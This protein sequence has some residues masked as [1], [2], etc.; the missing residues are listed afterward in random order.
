MLLDILENDYMAKRIILTTM[1][2]L[3][4]T[5]KNFYI[6]NGKYCD[7]ISQLEA[8][9]KYYLSKIE[10]INE[11]VVIGSNAT[12][13]TNELQKAKT[14]HVL[15]KN[16]KGRNIIEEYSTEE[17]RK[18]KPSAYSVY[19]YDIKNFIMDID[20]EN[21]PLDYGE[22]KVELIEQEHINK[23]IAEARNYILDA[24]KKYLNFYSELIEKYDKEYCEDKENS[25]EQF[26]KFFKTEEK[27]K[28]ICNEVFSKLV[29][30][31][32]EKASSPK[33]NE[34]KNPVEKERV[35]EIINQENAEYYKLFYKLVDHNNENIKK[36]E[37]YIL[38]A[39]KKYLNFYSE[40]IEKYDKEYCED[41][42]NSKEQFLKFFKTE[43]KDKDI[44]NE[45]FSK[46]VEKE[47]EKASSPKENEQ[48]NPVKK[49]R[50]EEILNQENAEYYEL[51]ADLVKCNLEIDIKYDYLSE[52]DKKKYRHN[53]EETCDDED[54]LSRAN[55]VTQNKSLSLLG[56]TINLRSLLDRFQ[57]KSIV[58]SID[59]KKHDEE[60]K[61]Y[62]DD[63]MKLIKQLDDIDNKRLDNEQQYAKEQIYKS[64][65][66]DQK[67]SCKEENKNVKIRFVS[68]KAK[69]KKNKEFDNFNGI[70][71]ALKDK[72]S[73]EDIEIYMDV[74]GGF[75]TDG[76]LRSAVL[77]F[78]NNL[79]ANGQGQRVQLKQVIA[80]AFSRTKF[81]NSIIDETVR[82]RITDLVSGMN[83]FIN[84]GKANQL[85]QT[86]NEVGHDKDNVIKNIFKNMQEVDQALSLCDVNLLLE[87]MKNLN[88]NMNRR[89]SVNDSNDAFIKVFK[90][91]ILEDYKGI[92]DDKNNVDVFELVK[93]AMRKG[94]IQQAIT[95]IESKMPVQMI[96]DGYF[97]IGKKDN[98]KRTEWLRKEE[99][100]TYKANEP[101][102][103]I[104]QQ[105]A[106]PFYVKYKETIFGVAKDCENTAEN[107]KGETGKEFWKIFDDGSIIEKYGL[108]WAMR[109]N[110]NHASENVMSYDDTEKHLKEFI[111]CYEQFRSIDNKK[112]KEM[113]SDLFTKEEILI[114]KG[115]KLADKISCAIVM[116][117]RNPNKNNG[118]DQQKM[119]CNVYYEKVKKL[120]DREFP[121]ENRYTRVYPK[122]KSGKL[123]FDITKYT[124]SFKKIIIPTD[125]YKQNIDYIKK[126]IS[127][128]TVYIIEKT[129]T[130]Y[131][132]VETKEL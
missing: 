128:C 120:F 129:K 61:K 59:S 22:K 110:T 26:L 27:D 113:T 124:D 91:N 67:L 101:E 72:K 107:G 65:D 29:E 28:D 40:L 12:I 17:N 30:K 87:A 106:H 73:N 115:G 74:Q 56:K 88:G 102:H 34:Q 49:E 100:Q 36:T 123:T 117:M 44:C 35:E 14:P 63:L 45:V 125:I 64:I 85:V 83:A 3:N 81:F 53:N 15:K 121:E 68:L 38:D 24:R 48:K 6:V 43:E 46:L 39:R 66:K 77:S 10:G 7:G 21:S 23:I 92:I 58:S 20:S 5:N 76:Y 84:Y 57:K 98:D 32:I 31:E 1:S 118:N 62:Q 116:R 94:F 111:S 52:K 132:I 70:L 104:V 2:T 103:Y 71:K 41:K 80:T 82:Y 90:D 69:N 33:E 109:N 112:K 95:L 50:V 55:E 25:K 99:P 97:C 4:G 47:I 51:F 42:E 127:D 122:K 37:N 19:S 108:I 13:N 18:L 130:S 75:R 89:I 8:G 114:L 54:I 86:W 60:I 96:K 131:K 93:W 105:A 119:E 79:N 78:L 9:T 126:E 11:I 16:Y